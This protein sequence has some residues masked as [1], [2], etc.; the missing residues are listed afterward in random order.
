MTLFHYTCSHGRRGIGMRGFL[1]PMPQPVLNGVE[2]V[3][4]TDQTE[5][6]RCGLGLT[7]ITLNC[8]RLEFRY[9]V[10]S[11]DTVRPW[12]SWMAE[13]PYLSASDVRALHGEDRQPEHWWISTKLLWAELDRE[14]RP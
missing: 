4:L 1:K 9:V 11:N 8:D 6:N 12:L 10:Q 13:Q 14:Y 2:L 7:S 5:P 3:W